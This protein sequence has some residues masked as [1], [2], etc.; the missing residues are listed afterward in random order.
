MITG[1]NYLSIRRLVPQPQKESSLPF[2]WLQDD[3][4]LVNMSAGKVAK[5]TLP[6]RTAHLS[7]SPGKT[8]S[9]G[10]VHFEGGSES[11]GKVVPGSSF[12]KGKGNLDDFVR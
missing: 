10:C 9:R 7:K 4:S 2:T 12:G 11:K 6:W 8:G 3:P 5:P 1:N